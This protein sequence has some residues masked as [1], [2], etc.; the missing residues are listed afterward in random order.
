MTDIEAIAARHVLCCS[1]DHTADEP[2]VCVE[3]LVPRCDAAILLDRLRESEADAE[4]LAKA[5]DGLIPLAAQ[6]ALAAHR[7][8]VEP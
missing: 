4:R 2:A 1:E 6:D 7:A 3:C 5:L 8:R